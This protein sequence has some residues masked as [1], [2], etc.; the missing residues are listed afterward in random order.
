MD[1]NQLW[2]GATNEQ[3]CRVAEWLAVDGLVFRGL[4]DA[5]RACFECDGRSF[6]LVPGRGAQL[7]WSRTPLQLSPSQR[8]S[9]QEGLSAQWGFTGTPEDLLAEDYSEARVAQV[10]SLL[11]QVAPDR[12]HSDELLS[13]D[14][15]DKLDV[16][17]FA[18]LKA[19]FGGGFRLPSPDE[20]EYLYRAGATTLFPWGDQWPEGS[21]YGHP[22]SDAQRPNA[23][24]LVFDLD[25]YCTEVVDSELRG[26]DGGSDACGGAP[27]PVDWRSLGCAYQPP[28]ELWTDLLAESLEQSV[29]RRVR[30]VV[31]AGQ[32]PVHSS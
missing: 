7:G 29:Y 6:V 12:V 22:L 15:A 20:W 4:D 1:D 9:W 13:E 23:F 5:G 21:S 28:A 19:S 25:T 27:N 3:R 16:D 14:D 8:R 30:A 10:G 32:L 26:G 17:P 2:T 24:G 31:L 11:V 18:A